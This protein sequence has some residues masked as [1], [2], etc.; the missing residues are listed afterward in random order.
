MIPSLLTA[1]TIIG[2]YLIYKVWEQNNDLNT[3]KA[4]LRQMT[5]KLLSERQA[6]MRTIASLQKS[7]QEERALTNAAIDLKAVEEEMN[8]LDEIEDMTDG[9]PEYGIGI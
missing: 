7:L 5:D 3:T 6:N 9:G 1:A 4:R 2:L 8:L